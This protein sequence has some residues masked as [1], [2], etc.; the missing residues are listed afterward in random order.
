MKYLFGLIICLFVY[1]GS[2]AQKGDFQTAEK[3]M[4]NKVKHLEGTLSIKPYF[5]KNTDKFWYAFQTPTGEEYFYADPKAKIHRKLLDKKIFCEGLSTLTGTKIIES[6]FSTKFF[7]DDINDSILYFQYKGTEFEF[8]IHTQNLQKQEKKHS[9]RSVPKSNIFGSYSPDSTY[10][11]YAENY[12]MYITNTKKAT[13][14]Q[15][16][17]DGEKYYSY[18]GGEI[19]MGMRADDNPYR[20]PP[21]IHWSS[22]SKYFFQLKED[23]RKVTYIPTINM[24]GDPTKT[25]D[26]KT[27]LAGAPDV[28]QFELWIFNTDSLTA[29]QVNI[30]KW[31]DQS[32]KLINSTG[33]ESQWEDQI[34]FWR[35]KRTNDEMEV[36]KV[37]LC[38]GEVK[39][40]IS[41]KSSP[42][43]A[44]ELFHIE[45]IN[46]AKEIIF[47]SERSGRGHYYHYDTDGNLLNTITSGNWTAGKIIETDEKKRVIYFQ[48]YGQV[49]GESPYY[50]RL[51]KASIDGK[52][53]VKILTPE[54]ATHNVRLTPSKSF[55]IDSYSRADLEPRHVVR[56]IEGK[57]ILELAK[58]D[59]SALY[60]TGWQMPE[61]IVVKAA[62]DSTLLYGY[63]WKPF[64]FDPAKKYP[65]ISYVYPGPQTELLSLEFSISARYNTALAQVGFIVVNFG[66]R[67]GSPLRNKAYHAFGYGNLR[68]YPLADDKYGLEQLAEKYPFI[69]LSRV[70]IFGHS[71]GGMMAAT[72]L[73]TYPDFYKAAVAASGNYDN[74]I[75]NKPFVETYQGIQE[76]QKDI[77]KRKKDPETGKD[78]IIIERETKFELKV[79]TTSELAGNL[80]GHLMLVTGDMDEN[81]HPAHTIRL[82]N[83]LIKAGKNFDFVILPGTRHAY[84]GIPEDFFEKKL[85]FHFAKH[86]LNDYG[87]E[88]VV[89]INRF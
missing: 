46:D 38:T 66:H 52:G 57:E 47:W 45:I 41:E 14:T 39:I 73:L 55:I 43:L 58:P 16:T 25:K 18:T 29:R 44:D 34:F 8:N 4:K 81:V 17:N 63:M 42:Y 19:F 7:Y 67:G 23:V 59:L 32:V 83:A 30:S 62:D 70:G 61:P 64:N 20:T 74:T 28:I 82:A 77:K 1:S 89:D 49:A 85:W 3:F 2:H 40:L 76:I 9:Q 56:N 68:D 86:L 22:D 36:C 80:K 78:T 35:K 72:A 10:V 60:A 13:T 88:R 54:E 71:G 51:N 84:S 27:S 75:Y 37:D 15:L 11:V 87:P 69:D 31:K 53:K 50:A 21:L 26:I 12:N 48:A 5:F 24:L 79:A 65:V 6:E 33:K